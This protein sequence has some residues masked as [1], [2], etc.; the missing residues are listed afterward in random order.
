MR[1]QHQALLAVLFCATHSFP[2]KT[3]HQDKDWYW[4][5]SSTSVNDAFSALTP[6]Q[7]KWQCAL[8]DDCK[9]VSQQGPATVHNNLQKAN[10]TSFSLIMLIIGLS[11][12]SVFQCNYLYMSSCPA[13]YWICLFWNS[14]S[15]NYLAFS[16][17]NPLSTK[18]RH[19]SFSLQSGCF[20]FFLLL[21]ALAGTSSTALNG[22]GQ[23]G[24]LCL[25]WSH[26]ERF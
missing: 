20:C 2:D 22:S 7:D 11:F 3:S 14:F 4:S 21:F 13:T 6:K 19:C 16:L 12:L 25:S 9:Y 1:G 17:G 10:T 24:H 8:A 23:S 26:G 5:F 18:S 15:V